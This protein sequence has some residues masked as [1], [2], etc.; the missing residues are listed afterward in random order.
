MDNI[1]PSIVSQCLPVK[2]NKIINK[3]A[4]EERIWESE[5]TE[6]R[7]RQNALASLTH[8]GK[9]ICLF[10]KMTAEEMNRCAARFCQGSIYAHEDTIK[11]GYISVDGG[12]R[13]GVCGTL[14]P[15]GRGV[16]EFT[17]LNIRLPHL[18]RG[19]CEPVIERC[20]S[21]GKPVS[22]LIYSI[23]GGGKTTLLR[24]LAITV[25]SGTK[26]IRTA[27]VDSRRELYMPGIFENTI[28]DIL[29]G[30]PKAMGIELAVRTLSPELIICDELGGET[31]TTAILGTQNS[32]IPL[33]ATAHASSL[34]KLLSKPNIRLLHEHR[35]FD[36]YAGIYRTCG[37][38][39]TL[40]RQYAWEFTFVEDVI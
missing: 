23:P 2:V 19:V 12:I 13:V 11:E 39:G 5:L 27:V 1:L 20:F 14:A 18:V 35:V 40:S 9:N 15:D 29:S 33:I 3:L 10:E 4:A 8:M 6:I 37:I 21:T 25:G 7:L 17:S 26:P 31:E 36:F 16:R 24:D 34:G 30:Y 28:C 32:G 38:D 22:I